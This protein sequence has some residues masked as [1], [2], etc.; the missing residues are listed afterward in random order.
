MS[1]ELRV[2]SCENLLLLF[3]DGF[4]IPV[5]RAFFLFAVNLLTLHDGIPV[6]KEGVEFRTVD[7]GE[8]DLVAKLDAAAAAHAGAVDHN[9]VE[10]GDAF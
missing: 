10:A 4:N 7:A 2:A 8:L 6:D 5:Q 9:R 1:C 3:F